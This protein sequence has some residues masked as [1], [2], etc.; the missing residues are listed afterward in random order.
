MEELEVRGLEGPQ[1][2]AVGSVPP[3][4]GPVM[5]SPKTVAIM[6]F[7][8]LTPITVQWLSWALALHI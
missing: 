5:P 4:L 8:Q 2:R 3:G 1:G 7:Q 6:V